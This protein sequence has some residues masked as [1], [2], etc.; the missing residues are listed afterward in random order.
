MLAPL[1][2]GALLVAAV[3]LAAVAWTAYGQRSEPGMAAFA[4]LSTLYA[5]VATAYAGTL[6]FGTMG[7]LEGSGPE[8]YMPIGYV[9]FLAAVPWL[10]FALQYTGHGGQV[11]RRRLGAAG[12]FGIVHFVLLA[13]Y[14]SLLPSGEMFPGNFESMA[15]MAVFTASFSTLLVFMGCYAVGA[16]LLLRTARAYSHMS[17]TMGLLLALPAL[18]MIPLYT[19]LP[20]VALGYGRAYA[21]AMA[22]ATLLFTACA[23][24]VVARYDDAFGSTSV[25]AG[26]VGRNTILEQHS[27]AVFTLDDEHRIVECNDA[28]REIFGLSE[29]QALGEPVESVLDAPVEELTTDATVNL[30]T[31]D[32]LWSETT[33]FLDTTHGRRRFDAEVTDLTDD[34]GNQLGLVISLEDVTERAI[35]EQRIGILNRVLRHNLR[36]KLSIVRGHAE[37]VPEAEGEL[38]ECAEAIETAASDLLSLGERARDVERVLAA[39]EDATAQVGAVTETV[40]D[41][42]QA[43]RRETT[44]EADVEEECRVSTTP[45]ALE[46]ALTELC[47]NAAKHNDASDPYV[48]IRTE[49]EEG[50]ASIDVVDNG[51]ALSKQELVAI[52]DESESPLQHGSGLGL[53]SVRWIVT[54]FGGELSVVENEPR[55][56]VVTIRL[57]IADEETAGLAVDEELADDGPTATAEQ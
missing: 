23:F 37:M 40:I 16:I 54:A 11:T 13:I 49:C 48:T 15:F 53:W 43:T 4:V 5:S 12:V 50:W 20:Q 7:L 51:P 9:G 21:G 27:E 19:Y 28:A 39:E 47:E 55:G 24:A 35:R 30:R 46:Y 26:P 44:F 17:T 31:V 57:P 45:E 6:V 22:G 1:A 38:E 32:D 29:Q 25:A 3:C 56:T 36:N 10:V 42:L 14:L 41:R 52:R 2:V 33:V 34:Q 18:S 8:I